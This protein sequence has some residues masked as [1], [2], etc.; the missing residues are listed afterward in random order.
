MDLIKTPAGWAYP[1]PGPCSCGERAA[2]RAWEFCRCPGAEGGGHPERRCKAC[3]KVRTL[4]CV[5]AVE[6]SSEYGG[7]VGTLMAPDRRSVDDHPR[8]A[9]S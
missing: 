8:A 1:D 4:G 3:G 7:K 9:G 6:V 5:G 2:M